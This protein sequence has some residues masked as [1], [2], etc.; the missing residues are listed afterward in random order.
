MVVGWR[1]AVLL[2]AL[3]LIAASLPGPAVRLSSCS[4]RTF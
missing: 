3:G 1:E 2:T 4:R